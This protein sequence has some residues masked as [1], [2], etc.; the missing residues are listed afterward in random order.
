[1]SFYKFIHLGNRHPDQDT[2]HFQLPQKG[3]CALS[4][5]EGASFWFLAP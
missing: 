1:M 5:S 3:I 2:E 4:L